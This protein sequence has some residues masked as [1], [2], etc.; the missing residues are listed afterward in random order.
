[1]RTVWF[2]ALVASICFEGLG[3]KF[4]PEIPSAVFYFTK[5]VILILGLLRFR[6]GADIRRTSRHLYRGYQ[7]FLVLAIAFTILQVFNPEQKS[8]LLA[9]I[10]LRA[11]W[12]WWAAPML[13]AHVVREPRERLRAIYVLIVTSAV[14]SLFAVLEFLIPTQSGLNVYS[15]VDG[16]AVEQVVLSETGRARVSSTFSFISGFAD[17]TILVPALIFSF[18][19]DARSP[20]LRKWAFI[21]TGMTAAVLPMSGSRMPLLV[22]GGILILSIWSAGLFFTRVG[23]RILV[24]SIMA[25]VGAVVV[26]PDA[27]AGIES[28]FQN[29][30]ETNSRYL[31]A[32]ASVL[33][34]LAI[35]TVKHPPFGIGTGMLQNVRVQMRIPIDWEVEQEFERYLV[36]LGT[37]GFIVMWITKFGLVVALYRAYQILKRAGRRGAATASLS[38]AVLTMI[39]NL[40]FDH[41]WQSLYFIGCGFILTEVVSALLER[42]A[43][44][45]EPPV[46]QPVTPQTLQPAAAARL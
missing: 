20:R 36:E 7:L 22:G 46:Q 42:A 18:G 8:S 39:G 41:V 23:R 12:L 35:A 3:R 26:F 1:M 10:G 38:Y 33:P 4:L 40:T 17:F 24:G 27:L 9:V 6:P 43:V 13:V 16:E 15:Y 2:A 11:Y 32:A 34:P 37:V 19:L 28:R 31:L 45:V 30:E 5:D 14:V 44:T 29:Q 21:V 25:A